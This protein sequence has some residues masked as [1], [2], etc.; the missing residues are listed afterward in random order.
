MTTSEL[1]LL[2]ID[3]DPNN[4]IVLNVSGNHHSVT[5]IHTFKKSHTTVIDVDGSIKVMEIAFSDFLNEKYKGVSVIDKPS[6]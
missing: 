4:K 3:E 2:L 1:A 6:L 5:G